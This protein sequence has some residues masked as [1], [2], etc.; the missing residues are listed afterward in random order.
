MTT[1]AAKTRAG[2]RASR[3]QPVTAAMMT[4][5]NR[6]GVEAGTK[7]RPKEFRMPLARAARLMKSRYGNMTR[8]MKMVR[9]H[10]PATSPK[11]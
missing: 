6:M 2:S 4:M 5:L 11:P 9:P 8:V 1:A 7:K 10:F 3:A